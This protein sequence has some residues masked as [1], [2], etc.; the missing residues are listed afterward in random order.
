MKGIDAGKLSASFLL[1]LH[2]SRF[3]KTKDDYCMMFS[4]CNLLTGTESPV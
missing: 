3:I 1:S 2:K 4:A